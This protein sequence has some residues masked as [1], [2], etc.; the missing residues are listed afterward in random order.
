MMAIPRSDDR[1]TL[2][3]VPK[4]GRTAVTWP[5][6]L[7]LGES[8]LRM[9]RIRRRAMA[10]VLPKGLRNEFDNGAVAVEGLDLEIKD[11]EFVVLLGPTGCGKTTTL[12]PRDE[13]RSS[14]VAFG[15]REEHKE[16]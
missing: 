8:L 14:S 16:R 13:R 12:P 11:R 9:A 1:Q 7:L 4:R 6:L 3:Y 15:R 10:E 5:F 2:A